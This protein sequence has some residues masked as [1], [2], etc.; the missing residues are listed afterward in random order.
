MQDEKDLTDS[1]Q[2]DG[3]VSDQ[4]T[5][6][7]ETDKNLEAENVDADKDLETDVNDADSDANADTEDAD[8]GEKQDSKKPESRREN[9]RIRQLVAKL[10]EER[11]KP[12]VPQHQGGLDYRTELNADDEVLKRLEA[13]RQA[14]A[15]RSFKEGLAYA[16]SV[17][18]HTRLEID[19]P[20]VMTKYPQFDQDSEHFNPVAAD[21]I[22]QWYLATVGY[23]AKTGMVKNP[24]VRYADFVE[25]IMELADEMAGHKV[26]ESRRNIT[27]QAANTGLRPDSNS[28]KRLNLNKDPGA[29]T[30]EELDAVLGSAGLLPK[31]R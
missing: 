17:Q 9:L 5:D 12:H 25:G 16:D 11:A 13:D 14:A 31:K 20:K 23:D 4:S 29:M 15:E 28:T 26:A 3:E 24:N 2:I 22:N 1:Q 30:D 18:F 7:Q 10:Q 8:E 27:N 21:A 19:T 6:K